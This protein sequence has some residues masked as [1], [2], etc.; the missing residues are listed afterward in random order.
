MNWSE[1][2]SKNLNR[3]AWLMNIFSMAIVCYLCLQAIQ[4]F[5]GI[6]GG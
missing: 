5:I 4:Y 6:L 1:K 3:I 2:D